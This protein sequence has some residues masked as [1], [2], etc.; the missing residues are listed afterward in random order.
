MIGW[1]VKRLRPLEGW[2]AF[3]LLLIT[4]LCLP[5]AVI[6]AAWVPE[7]DGLPWLVLFAFLVGRW[8]ALRDGCGWNVWLPVGVLLGLLAGISVAAYVVPFL[9]GSKE[10]TLDFVRR[11]VIWL[12]A[13][14][15]GGTSNDPAIFLFYIALLCWGAVLFAAWAFY[16]RQRP[17]LALL[18]LVSLCALTVFYSDEG[19]LW[20]IAELGCGVPLLAV[21]NLV[22]V[23]RTWDTTGV[24]YAAD[25]DFD[26]LIIALLVAVAVV[27]LSFFGPLLNVRRISTWFWQTFEEPIARVQETMERLFGG[28]YLPDG[29]PPGD[30]GTMPVASSYL[31]QSRLLGG[32]PD[33]LEQVMLV[34]WTDELP[35]PPDDHPTASGDL[36]R[37][38][39]RGATLDHYSGRGWATTVDFR[40]EVEGELPLPAPPVYR[41]VTQRFEFTAP[42]G[43]TLYALNQPAWVE[44]P[45]VVVWHGVGDL[46]GLASEVTSYTIVSRLP[47]PTAEDLRAVSS[48]YSLEIHTRYLQLP[49]T[50][51][52]RVIDLAQEVVAEGETAYERARLLERYLRAYPYSLEVE[53]PPEGWDVADYFL[54]GTREG[55][56]DYYATTFVVMA[57]AVGIPARLASGYTGGQYDFASGSYV[58]RQLNGHSWPEVYFTDW[59]WIGFEPTGARPVTEWPEEMSLPEEALPGPTGIPARVVRFRWRVAGWGLA[60]L[61][62]VSLV[63]V[64]WSRY[65]RQRAALVVTLPLVWGWVKHGGARLGLPPDPALTPQEYTATLAAELRARA[66]QARRWGERW[67]GLAAQGGAALEVLGV[68]YSA[69]VYG[70]PQ[71]AAVDEGVVQE[72]WGQLRGPLRRFRWLGWSQRLGMWVGGGG[73]V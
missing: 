73:Q 21:G 15:S 33:L 48:L 14:F 50:V 56:C 16:R 57:R 25:L 28:V 24:D 2:T 3:L 20:L 35:P 26:L 51:P 18:P 69:Q 5:A 27:L 62:G 22:R 38:Y 63:M 30:A 17:L 65:S 46:A 70:G 44:E 58:V 8:L 10:A 36:P 52:Q 60:L 19:I 29:G 61:V 39:W 59:G 42:H 9:P 41:Q 32:R 4:V 45:V 34:V 13:A 31:P 1:P 23:Q 37:H 47:M 66:E 54:F 43:D 55:Y 6:A 53:R 64:V 68:L 72:V 12:E 71:V 40:Q 11:W 67:A 49:E 7:D